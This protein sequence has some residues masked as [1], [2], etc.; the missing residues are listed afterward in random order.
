MLS[1]GIFRVTKST[2]GVVAQEQFRQR[3]TFATV[4]ALAEMSAGSVR[5]RTSMIGFCM[6]SHRKSGS[7]MK[8]AYDAGTGVVREYRGRG[9][10]KQNYLRS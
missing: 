2:C 6:K 9:I 10:G 7:G 3:I 8:T 1:R 5:T 4:S